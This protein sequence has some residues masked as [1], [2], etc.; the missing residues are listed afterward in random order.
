MMGGHS[1]AADGGL[2][3]SSAARL[4]S[5]PAVVLTMPGEPPSAPSPAAPPDAA[6]VGA[7]LVEAHDEWQTGDRRYLAEGIM[8]LL[9]PPPR[10]PAES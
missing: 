2:S 7:M 3:P 5:C 10:A 4:L 6:L 1:D 9:T 8:A